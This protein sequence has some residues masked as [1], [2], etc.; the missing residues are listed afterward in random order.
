M[1]HFKTG[2]CLALAAALAGC[3]TQTVNNSAGKASIYA[4][5]QSVTYGS[6]GL[7]IESQD[8]VGATDQM[9][10]DMLANPALAGQAK[11]PRVIID[12]EYF[13]N[14]STT[15]INMNSITDRLRVNL[16]RAA[17]GRMV[18]VGRQNIAM[19]EKERELKREGKVDGGTIRSTKATAG[20]DYRMAGRISSLDSMSSRTGEASRYTQIV[21][22]MLDLELGTV[23]WSGIYEFK[24]SGQDDVIYR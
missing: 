22:E 12:A 4:D 20:A 7:G 14:E 2:T 13:V 17:N 16:N 21:F 24:K 10:R 3:Q 18:F 5:P 8:I 15:R 6:A 9:M 1:R 23:V 19:V 11:P